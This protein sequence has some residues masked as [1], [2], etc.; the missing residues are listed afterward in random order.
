MGLKYNHIQLSVSNQLQGVSWRLDTLGKRYFIDKRFEIGFMV[1]KEI[2]IEII[3][4]IT[5]IQ[6]EKSNRC[7]GPSGNQWNPERALINILY[8]YNIP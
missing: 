6:A 1:L 8:N 2:E 5:S 3:F 7:R 4:S